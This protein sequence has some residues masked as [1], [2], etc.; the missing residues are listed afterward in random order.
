MSNLNGADF[1]R[2]QLI[3][4]NFS[5]SDLTNASFGGIDGTQANF[6]HTDLHG[7]D[8]SG[9]LAPPAG[10]EITCS[11]DFTT[12]SSVPPFPTPSQIT[13][14]NISN[15]RGAIFTGAFAKGSF[16]GGAIC[17]NGI[18]WGHA[19]ANCPNGQTVVQ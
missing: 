10:G 6:A 15:L 9:D 19:G 12:C 14:T 5:S 18:H 13:W 2:T 3:R 1:N 17:P 16:F 8:F 4:A 7:T 11:K